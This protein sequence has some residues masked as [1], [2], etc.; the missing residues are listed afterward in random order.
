VLKKVLIEEIIIGVTFLERNFDNILNKAPIITLKNIKKLPKILENNP[1]I[2]TSPLKFINKIQ[3]T[4][5][6]IT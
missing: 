2:A 4:E 1:D 5:K 6:I 3:I